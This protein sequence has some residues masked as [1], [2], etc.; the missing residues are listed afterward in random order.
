MIYIG[1]LVGLFLLVYGGNILVDGS[2]VLAKRLGVSSLLIGLI[3]VGFG[4]ST[5][6]L[7]A[8]FISVFKE[9][10]GI[11]VGNIIGSNIAN[12][13]LVLGTTSFIH[14]I[15]ID[16]KA[17]KRDGLFLVV[18]TLF[19][20]FGVFKGF[21]G[22]LLG[23]I[24]VGTLLV[25]VCYSYYS[26]KKNYQVLDEMRNKSIRDP[27]VKTW[28]SF[29]KIFGGISLTLLGAKLLVEN[30]VELARLW[31]VSETVIGLTVV[32]VGTSLP[33]LITSVIASIKKE[34]GIAFGNVV[35]SNIY[36]ALFI[37][38]TVAVIL[39]IRIPQGMFY[40]T[41]VMIIATIVLCAIT[42]L[43]GQFS[44]IIGATFLMGYAGY[45]WYLF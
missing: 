11:A 38:G 45:V 7:M 32:A 37:L 10:N 25:Y 44:R 27:L 6:E 20:M 22:H 12:I 23:C 17:F 33:E 2:V 15:L 26:D 21:I 34:N 18:A 5:P 30:A 31:N 14:P 29:I 40:D 28:I 4:T 36:N 42:F 19:L 8:S 3:L 13:L 43:K 16:K 35:G 41:V 39:P 24:F 9:S 1:L